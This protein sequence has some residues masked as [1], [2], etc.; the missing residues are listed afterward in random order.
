MRM[1]IAAL[2]PKLADLLAAPLLALLVATPLLAQDGQFVGQDAEAYEANLQA[3]DD[4]NGDI[5][6]RRAPV[7]RMPDRFYDQGDWY[8]P[9]D[10]TDSDY[11]YFDYYGYQNEY[12]ESDV[13]E[14]GL[15]ENYVYD[16]D[17]YDLDLYDDNEIDAD[18]A[19]GR[20]DIGGERFAEFTR[21]RLSDGDA[22]EPG[23]N[24]YSDSW[25]GDDDAFDT[26]YGS[27]N[28]FDGGVGGF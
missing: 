28:D 14:D 6:D 12:T 16:G 22:Y 20:R 17:L 27:F 10:V 11:G 7:R 3:D 5:D 23:Y 13:Y 1:P 8:G 26:W 24:Y 25:Y 2:P 18:D 15:S 21:G 4:I 9:D 19:I